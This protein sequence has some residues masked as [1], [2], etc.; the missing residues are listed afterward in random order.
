M[1]Q[2]HAHD[3]DH[4]FATYTK[5][6]FFLVFLTAITVG[7]AT[8]DLGFFN[9]PIALGIATVKAAFVVLFFMHAKGANR[10]VWICIISSILFLIILLGLTM[11]DYTTRINYQSFYV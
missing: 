9:T 5:V 10:L 3:H 6:Y 7:V 11:S 8:Q 4:H 2:D 1:S